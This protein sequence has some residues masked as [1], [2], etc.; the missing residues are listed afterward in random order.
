MTQK[1]EFHIEDE[2]FSIVK[3][4]RDMQVYDCYIEVSLLITSLHGFSLV[5][6]KIYEC[7]SKK[8]KKQNSWMTDAKKIITFILNSNHKIQV[9]LFGYLYAT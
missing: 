2:T 4:A 8:K 1:V 3:I 6:S 7:F 5:I 9:N